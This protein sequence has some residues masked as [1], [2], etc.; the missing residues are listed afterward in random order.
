MIAVIFKRL[1]M[2]VDRSIWRS[3]GETNVASGKWTRL[4]AQPT[5]I[6]TSEPHP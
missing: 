6:W 5:S 3:Q 2:S 1:I 4:A